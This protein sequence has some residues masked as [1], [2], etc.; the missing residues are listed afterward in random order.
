[1]KSQ[2][3]ILT[4]LSFN[5]QLLPRSIWLIL[6]LFCLNSLSGGII[7]FVFRG[8]P[9]SS[10]ESGIV[11]SLD[12]FPILFCGMLATQFF[13]GGT[14]WAGTASV[15]LMPAGEFLLVR[16]IPRSAAYLSR[17][18]LF[19][20]IILAAPLLKVSVTVADPNLR[21][22][23]YHSKT[24]S[25]EAADK[26]TLYK[27]QFPNSFIMRAPKTNHD[28]LV[29]PFGAV[30]IALWEFWLATLLALA[31]Q[32]MTLLTLPS[33]VQIGLLMAISL[34]P[35]LMITFSPFG[36]RAAVIESTVFFFM[37]YWCLIAL[38]TLAAFILVQ[39]IALKRTQD[40]EVI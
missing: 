32:T 2:R 28:M 18:F 40:L 11:T 33:K 23:L 17:I 26:L 38:F 5:L 19:F 21:M 14:G 31:L 37:H 6:A 16:P 4:L 35:M 3:T 24:Q 25:T 29:V 9:W 8:E 22:S 10:E 34:A 1:M 39:G 27:H 13:I 12:A 36:E 7:S 15:W 20:V 30:L